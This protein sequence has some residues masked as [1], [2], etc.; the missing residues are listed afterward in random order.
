VSLSG[1]RIEP[2]QS[3]SSFGR[4]GR[5][6]FSL[7]APNPFQQREHIRVVLLQFGAHKRIEIVRAEERFGGLGKVF[8]VIVERVMATLSTVDA[9]Q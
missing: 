9:Q 5:L 7:D 4:L 8:F 1:P 2:S 6:A 3:L